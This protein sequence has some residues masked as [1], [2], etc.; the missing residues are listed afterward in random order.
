MN[1][2]NHQRIGKV[3]DYDKN[4]QLSVVSNCT[5]DCS[6]HGPSPVLNI[7]NFKIIINTPSHESPAAPK[8][9]RIESNSDSD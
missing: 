1:T 4:T 6:R 5:L 9:I 2:D 3:L 8:K 7:Q